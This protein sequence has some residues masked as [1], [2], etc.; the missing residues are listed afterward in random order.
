VEGCCSVGGRCSLDGG[1]VCAAGFGAY[2]ELYVLLP[3]SCGARA[4]AK[5]GPIGF[6]GG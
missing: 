4:A 2:G 1:A 6:V 3:A 5:P